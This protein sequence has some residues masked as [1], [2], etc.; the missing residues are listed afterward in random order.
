MFY[1]SKSLR[2]LIII[3]AAAGFL[4]WAANVRAAVSSNPVSSLPAIVT[5]IL[6]YH[7]I[8]TAPAT[9]SLPGLY[10]SPKIFC[11]QLQELQAQKYQTV[12]VSEVAASLRAHRSLPSKSVALSFDDGYEDFYTQAWP[13]LQRYQIKST[14]YV[15]IN[16]LD[17]P[18]YLTSAQ[19]KLLAQS[20]LVEI[21]SHTFNHPDLR[22]STPRAAHY[23]IVS[24]RGVLERLTGQKILTFAYPYG[25]YQPDL[26]SLVSEAGYLGAVTVKPGAQQDSGDLWMMKRLRPE[27]RVGT[28]FSNWLKGWFNKKALK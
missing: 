14:V 28:E 19:V 11:Q 23:E 1:P 9:T 15:I 8:E 26:F 20:K 25:Y 12:F 2:I 27:A 7:Y 10:L 21:G 16:A 3:L 13:W 6:M 4:G 5:P 22:K 17:K 24:S 18:G